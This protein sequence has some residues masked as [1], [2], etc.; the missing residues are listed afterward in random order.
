MLKQKKVLPSQR[1]SCYPPNAMPTSPSLGRLPTTP[2]MGQRLSFSECRTVSFHTHRRTVDSN[3]KHAKD[4]LS[5]GDT[6][7]PCGRVMAC[8]PC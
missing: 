6:C 2:R 4:F 7:E 8:S 5:T 1:N 3:W